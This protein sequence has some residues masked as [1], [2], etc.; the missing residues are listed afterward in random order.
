VNP[1][2]AVHQH[3]PLLIWC[4]LSQLDERVN[5]FVSVGV[6][7]L[8]RFAIFAEINVAA[9]HAFKSIAN[10]RPTTVIAINIFVNS[11]IFHTRVFDAALYFGGSEIHSSDIQ[12]L[13]V[14]R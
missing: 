12:Y 3:R 7:C 10:Y 2:V 9:N 14:R 6:G 4:G 8:F 13:L 11:G 5:I 1:C